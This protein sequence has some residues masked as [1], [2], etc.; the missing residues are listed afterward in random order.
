MKLSKKITDKIFFINNDLEFNDI[1]LEIFRYQYIHN[2]VYNDFVDHLKVNAYKIERYLDIP[3]LPVE[4]FKTRKVYTGE[5]PYDIIF[6]SS[7]TGNAVQ[8]QHYVKDRQIYIKSFTMAFNLNY[9]DFE[10]FVF[11]ALLP[12]YLERKGSSLLFMT[13]HFIEQSSHKES[14]YFLYNHEELYALIQKLLQSNKR[15]F[16]FGVTF[17][18][19]DFIAKYNIALRSNDIVMETGGMKGRKKEM[20]RE[21][22]HHVLKAGFGISR[23]HSEYGM[24]ELLSQAYSGGEG[25]FSC[26]PWLKVLVR[27]INDPLCLFPANHSGGIN[28]IDL[29]NI[30]SCSFLAT[31]DLGKVYENGNFE[32]SGRFDTS[33][34]RGCNLLSI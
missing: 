8:S 1:A 26:P 12:S 15:I 28:I 18:L 22:V 32:V 25:V 14:G 31:Q 23:I 27:D 10:D 4:F 30:H 3:F 21:E 20:I 2:K 16:L 34:I 11:L 24:T 5:E 29:A 7:G 17:A 9:G 6:L 13:D 19:T 33:D